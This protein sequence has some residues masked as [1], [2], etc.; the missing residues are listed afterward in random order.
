MIRDYPETKSMGLVTKPHNQCNGILGDMARLIV[1]QR[2]VI[3]AMFMPISSDGAYLQSGIAKNLKLGL[4][5][6]ISTCQ[7]RR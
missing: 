7:A 2:T 3:R 4:P 6:P 1:L 5:P